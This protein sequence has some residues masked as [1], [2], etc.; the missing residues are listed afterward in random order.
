M[1]KNKKMP[2]IKGTQSK[3][4][5]PTLLKFAPLPSPESLEESSDS[6]FYQMTNDAMFHIIFETYPDA[7]KALVGAL[8]RLSLEKITSIEVTNPV[9]YD[10]YSKNFVLD[11][12]TI[13]NIEM[14]VESLSFW[15]ECSLVYVC[16]IF[17]NLNCDDEYLN[18]KLCSL[19]LRLS[20]TIPRFHL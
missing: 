12:K 11:L 15:K 18:I 3:I 4:K 6:L 13:L 9:T 14:Q 8:L 20:Q 5:H 17:D 16:C 2:I 10:F 19:I 1:S 7:L